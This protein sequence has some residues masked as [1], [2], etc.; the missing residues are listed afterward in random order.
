MRALRSAI[1]ISC[2]VFVNE[3][4]YYGNQ[5]GMTSTY[6]KKILHLPINSADILVA[7]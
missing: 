6:A 1:P 7:S 4:M 5:M 3:S 2:L